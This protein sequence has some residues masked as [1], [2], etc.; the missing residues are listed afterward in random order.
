VTGGGQA[1]IV[2]GV[3]GVSS[4]SE[5]TSAFTGNVK[6]LDIVANYATDY[7][8]ATAERI[9]TAALSAHPN[10][11]VVVTVFRDVTQGAIQAIKSA[12]KRPGVDIKVCSLTGGTAQMLGFVKSG[13]VTLDQYVN[14]RW[15]GMAAMQ[16]LIDAAQG[17]S[18]PRVIAPG[19]NGTVTQ[20]TPAWPTFYDKAT[21]GQYSPTGE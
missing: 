17:K 5:L 1:I 2:N 9:T 7:T 16:S 6:G 11:K 15:S 3:A 18:E 20:M 4:S 8:P 12:G 19:P 13:E 10:V 21:A 14:D